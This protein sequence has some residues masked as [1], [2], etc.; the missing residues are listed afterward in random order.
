[1]HT[2]EPLGGDPPCWAH[3]F[4]QDA[5]ESDAVGRDRD[6]LAASSNQPPAPEI[7]VVDLVAVVRT[8]GHGP[9]T[10]MLSDDLNVNLLAFGPGEGVAEH[11]NAEV[12]VLLIG[13]AGEGVVTI[14][15]QPR[16]LR[17]G[18]AV[19]VPKGTRRGIRAGGER[20]SYL[21]CHRRRPGLRPS[22]RS[23]P[24]GSAS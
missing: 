2:N 17:L 9:V 11:E 7:D 1:M 24:I 20:F 14:D 5:A 22:V 16:A 12:D 10:T 21:T 18:Q 4:E 8:G 23:S 6:R 19:L 15:G 3:L 13:I